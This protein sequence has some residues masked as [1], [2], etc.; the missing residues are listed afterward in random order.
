MATANFY[1]LEKPLQSD[2]ALKEQ[3]RVET[4]QPSFTRPKAEGEPEA[5]LWRVC[6]EA[7]SP[8]LSGFEWIAFLLLGASTFGALGYCFTASFHFLTMDALDQT[9]RAFLTK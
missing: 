6:A 4:G 1:I 7:A 2:R 3:I 5:R 9:V 8:W